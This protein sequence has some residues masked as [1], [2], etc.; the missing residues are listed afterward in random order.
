MN[1][2]LVTAIAIIPLV[3]GIASLT[4]NTP[5]SIT[6]CRVCCSLIQ[7]VD[8]N[9]PPAEPTLVT[10]T[11]GTAPYFVSVLPGGE[12]TAAPLKSLGSSNAMSVTWVANVTPNQY[13]TFALK[14]STGETAFTDQVLVQ[15]NNDVSCMS[16]S[17]T[18][19]ATSTDSG[20]SNGA[21]STAVATQAMSG[22]GQATGSAQGSGSKTSTRASAATGATNDGASLSVGAFGLTGLL[23]FVGIVLF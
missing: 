8:I 14:D 17:S 3:P 4:I 15:A 5:A 1:K 12:T 6:Q 18:S 21:T 2:F 9:P 16:G 19:A 7:L 22:T 20:A 13:I 11:G 10:W 23:G